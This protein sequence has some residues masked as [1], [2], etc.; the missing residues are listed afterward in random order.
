MN[1]P[2]LA[3]PGSRSSRFHPADKRAAHAFTRVELAAVLAACALLLAIVLPALGSD[4]IRTQRA[5]CAN[6]LSRIGQTLASWAADHD[7]GYPWLIFP[8]GGG[9]RGDSL[10]GRYT[11][12]QFAAL[13]NEL[14]TPSA[15]ACPSD[16][17]K[18]SANTFAYPNFRDNNVSYLLCHPSLS[19]G[20][21]V[22]SGDRNIGTASQTEFCPEF[23][24]AQWLPRPQRT[25][26]ICGF[27]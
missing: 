4:S 13:S 14:V 10:N 27:M 26:G 24:S 25:P 19:E 16:G 20:R 2:P 7:E 21:V 17:S 9:T 1:A 22:L 11:Y 15:L 18:A 6:N 12:F 23:G 8:S 3:V 5:V